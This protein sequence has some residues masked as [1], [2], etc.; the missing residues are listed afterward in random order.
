MSI[1]CEWGEYVA[2]SVSKDETVTM[3]INGSMAASRRPCVGMNEEL[4]QYAEFTKYLGI[5]VSERIN[6]KL[7][8]VRTSVKLTNVVGQM[9]R[10]L[11]SESGI[12]KLAVRKI[13]KELFVGCV[14]YVLCLWCGYMKSKYA[15]DITNRCHKILVY[16]RLNVYRT[17]LTLEKQKFMSAIT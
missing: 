10:V 13:Y 1:V 15:R 12:R 4:F 6:F 14:M 11:N 2:E 16:A 9:G 3:F 7:H 17:A 8:I 5:S